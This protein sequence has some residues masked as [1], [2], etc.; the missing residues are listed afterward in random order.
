MSAKLMNTASQNLP[1]H[2]GQLRGQMLH[3]TDYE[4]AVT[5]FLEEFAGDVGFLRQSEPDDARH[6]LAVVRHVTSRA[7]NRQV[8]FDESKVFRLRAHGFYHGSAITDTRVIL[9]FYFEEA[10]T[11]IAALI[12]HTRSGMEV[13][14][15]R[16]TAGLA[17]PRK[18]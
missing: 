2:L 18:N 3:P 11:G 5:Y 9:F 8:T 13:A 7:M 4:L 17:D 16:L 12:P 15:F 10:D 14:R 1:H 6:L